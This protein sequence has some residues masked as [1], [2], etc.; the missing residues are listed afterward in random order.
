[1]DIECSMDSAR[2]HYIEHLSKVISDREQEIAKLR[3][4]VSVVWDRLL[5][6]PMI[7]EY[8]GRDKAL[9]LDEALR[10]V[11]GDIFGKMADGKRINP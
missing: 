6:Y 4:A 10:V 3:E 2:A 1:M 8:V 11:G 5:E 9:V 7:L